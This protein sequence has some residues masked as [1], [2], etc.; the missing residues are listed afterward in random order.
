[1]KRKFLLFAV[2][3][4]LP[5]GLVTAWLTESPDPIDET[6]FDRV[7]IGM[8]QS[9]AIQILGEPHGGWTDAEQGEIAGS[10]WN[11]KRN[12]LTIIIYF[13]P[14]ED[15]LIIH[16]KEIEYIPLR[17]RAE[18]WWGKLTGNSSM[19]SRDY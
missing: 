4:L 11:D 16:K 13:R 6:N 17:K 5:I 19:D 8:T 2:V 7:E 14:E 10:Y 3:S 12:R 1:M 15:R 9:Q 18:I